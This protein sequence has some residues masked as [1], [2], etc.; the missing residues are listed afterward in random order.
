MA[1]STSYKHLLPSESSLFA[2]NRFDR[3]LVRDF[4]FVFS[5]AEY[6]LKKAG[7]V[8]AGFNDVPKIEWREFASKLGDRLLNCPDEAI[9]SAELY[10]STN[11]PKKQTYGPHGL[12]WRERSRRSDQSAAQFLI[13]SATQVRHNLF[14]GGKDLM[15]RLAERDSELVSAALLVIAFAISL[16]SEIQKAFQDAGPTIVDP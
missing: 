6:A 13:E 1:V 14:H 3:D 15:G 8:H 2:S 12:E 9:E 16:D 7:F 4:L 5:R 11:P 10:L